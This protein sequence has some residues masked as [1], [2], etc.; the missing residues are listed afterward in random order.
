[1]ETLD[2]NKK[3]L[4]DLITWYRDEWHKCDVAHTEMIEKIKET[5]DPKLLEL[6]WKV[7][8]G[9]LDY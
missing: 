1:M 4:I 2:D 7:T 8:D 5:D 3:A 9:W 6:Y